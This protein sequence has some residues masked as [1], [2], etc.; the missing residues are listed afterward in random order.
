MDLFE[1]VCLTTC[2]VVFRVDLCFRN[3]MG[4]YNGC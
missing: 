3:G 4:H 2:S 1:I